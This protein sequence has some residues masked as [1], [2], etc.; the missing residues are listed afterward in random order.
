MTHFQNQFVVNWL[1]RQ[2]KDDHQRKKSVF[3]LCLQTGQASAV[4][5]NIHKHR[6]LSQLLSW[7]TSSRRFGQGPWKLETKGRFSELALGS[8]NYSHFCIFTNNRYLNGGSLGQLLPMQNPFITFWVSLRWPPSLSLHTLTSRCHG[9]RV[10]VN[11]C[12][13]CN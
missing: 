9:L 8:G 3:S 13:T 10:T 12:N 7:L 1:R 11:I 5:A 4:K 2:F 6:K